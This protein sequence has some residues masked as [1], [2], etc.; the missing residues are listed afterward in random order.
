MVVAAVGA[1]H[2]VGDDDL[3]SEVSRGGVLVGDMWKVSPKFQLGSTAQPWPLIVLPEHLTRLQDRVE[4]E[5][6]T[7]PDIQGVIVAVSVP[8]EVVD[9]AS[10]WTSFAAKADS[11]LC[12]GWA[13]SLGVSSVVAFV[14]PPTL[15]RFPP[16]ETIIPPVR[17]EESSLP[18]RHVLVALTVVRQA[19]MPAVPAFSKVG[20]SRSWKDLKAADRTGVAR[21]CLEVDLLERPQG[22]RDALAFARRALADLVAKTS[23]SSTLP[24]L[25]ALTV[26]GDVLSGHVDLPSVLA[27]QL[28][29]ASGS[30][31]GLFVRP[32]LGSAADFP[33]PDGFT[34]TSHRVVWATVARFSDVVAAALRDAGV[35]FAGLVCPRRRGELGICMT[36]GADCSSLRQCLEGDFDAKVKAP[37]VRRL[38]LRAS[39]VPLAMLDKLALLVAR[40]DPD[41]TLVAQRV[42][43]TTYDSLVADLTVESKDLSQ[44]PQEEWCLYGLGTRPVVIKR[45]QPR[46]PAPLPRVSVSP[47]G[48][49]VTPQRPLTQAEKTTWADR[50]RR[51]APS[52]EGMQ[53]DGILSAPTITGPISPPAS[54]P[55]AVSEDAEI[56]LRRRPR[57]ILK[58]PPPLSWPP[59]GSPLGRWP[60]RRPPPLLLLSLPATPARSSPSCSLRPSQAAPRAPAARRP[61]LPLARCT[62][63][64]QVGLERRG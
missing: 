64:P 7:N 8:R 25:R 30:I 11:I 53:V 10:D 58:Q 1:S 34:A 18:L 63:Q 9:E 29:R 43:R 62:A 38:T 28:L 41:L 32:W 19:A 44:S 47:S 52:R 26:K 12:S 2:I 6:S 56:P 33:L 59:P 60:A 36:Q 57:G 42:A 40:V 15:L 39:N 31:R 27:G 37:S 16:A 24:P 22:G 55:A 5:L 21:V 54:A 20:S 35:D 48:P 14:E 45:L 50:V 4:H 23:A 13:P 61:P 51:L 17:W 46:R 3:D 49:R